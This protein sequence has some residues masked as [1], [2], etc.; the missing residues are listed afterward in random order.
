MELGGDNSL[1]VLKVYPGTGLEDLAREKGILTE[2]FT[3]TERKNR[4]A[5]SLPAVGG[6]APLFTDGLAWEDMMEVILRYAEMNRCSL[7]G[8]VFSVLR[9]IRSPGDLKRFVAM[10]ILFV[11]HRGMPGRDE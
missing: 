10:G 2:D 11:K 5:V 6:D 3:W 9:K 4:G 8:R 1:G 7:R